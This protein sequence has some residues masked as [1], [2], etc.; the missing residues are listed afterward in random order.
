MR[1]CD[2][3]IGLLLAGTTGAPAQERANQHR[4]AIVIPR[5]CRRHHQ[6]NQ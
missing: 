2:F 4:I 6:R 3:T 1:R 5:R